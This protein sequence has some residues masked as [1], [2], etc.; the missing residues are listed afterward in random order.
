V[1]AFSHRP[2]RCFFQDETRLGLH[3]SQT[4]RRITARGVKPVQPMLPRYE[5]LWFFGAVEPASG[6]SFFLELPA[7]DTVCFQAFLTE[8]SEAFPDTLNVLV[9][10]GAPAHVARALK[11][12]DNLS[13]PAFPLTRPSSIRSSASGSTSASA[14]ATTCPRISLHWPVRPGR[15]SPTTPARPSPHSPTT[16]TLTCSECTV[17]LSSWYKC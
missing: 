1:V 15:F 12:P 6:E 17:N 9:L 14:L 10:D 16:A 4:R 3:E 8:F 2:V 7:L 5:Y 13:S 11:V